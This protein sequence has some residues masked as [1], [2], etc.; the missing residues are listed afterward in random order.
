MI[1]RFYLQ[2]AR[3]ANFKGDVEEAAEYMLKMLKWHPNIS[4][5]I[6]AGYYLLKIGKTDVARKV[7]ENDIMTD[8]KVVKG[9]LVKSDGS[10]KINRDEML[11]KTNYALL[12]WKEGELNRAI[13]LTEYVF[14][15]YKTTV[16]YSN[17][18][19]F[20]ILKGDLEKALDFNLEAYDFAPDNNVIADNLGCTYLALGDLDEADAF[21]EELMA[22]P[23]PPKFPE[24]Y[25][26]Y[27]L[28][29]E[30]KGEFQQALE[31]YRKAESFPFSNLSNVGKEDVE[32]AIE[33]M[34]KA[35]QE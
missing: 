32:E 29:K 14:K 19:Y 25:Y 6:L 35:V 26:N 12:L 8:R 16:V 2:K 1:W 5:K 18:G 3:N 7:F 15:R 11:A 20:Y 24:A 4:S 30:K 17:L 22:K 33:R 34:E 10:I 13:E 21:Y 31:L 23:K 9:D 27:G 28:V